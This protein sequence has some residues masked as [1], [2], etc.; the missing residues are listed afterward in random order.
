M[1]EDKVR[2]LSV[3]IAR[4]DERL[5]SMEKNLEKRTA[6]LEMIGFGGLLAIASMVGKA[7][8]SSIGLSD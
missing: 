6:R 8:F 3:M 4:I 1:D 5:N 2:D 7:I